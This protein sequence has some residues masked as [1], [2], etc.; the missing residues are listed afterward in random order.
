MS[1]LTDAQTFCL[2][3]QGSGWVCEVHPDKPWP[4]CNAPGVLC[5]NPDCIAGRVLRA[6]LLLR[7]IENALANRPLPR[8]LR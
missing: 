7:W 4:H 1:E 3:C 2:R 5:S 8:T 6:E